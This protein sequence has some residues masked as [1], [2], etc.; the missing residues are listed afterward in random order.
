M[1]RM[2]VLADALKCINNAEKRGKR[3]VLLRPCSKVIVRFL[4]VMMKHGEWT[5]TR[6]HV[7]VQL[8]ELT[9][10]RRGKIS[11]STQ[12]TARHGTINCLPSRR[13]WQNRRT[14]TSLESWVWK[15]TCLEYSTAQVIEPPPLWLVSD[16]VHRETLDCVTVVL[17]TESTNKT[18]LNGLNSF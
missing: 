10:S 13:P 5:L 9:A 3:Q 16:H 4:T 8:Q 1:V 18:R 11:V 15:V 7:P 17:E 14:G 6:H 2:N 12:I